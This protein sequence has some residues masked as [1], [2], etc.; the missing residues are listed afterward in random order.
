MHSRQTNRQGFSMQP[1]RQ[2]EHE[3]ARATSSKAKQ[4]RWAARLWGSGAGDA[5]TFKASDSSNKKRTEWEETDPN[6]AS[7]I[8]GVDMIGRQLFW[9]NAP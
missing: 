8:V 7:P 1:D 3:P 2:R 4:S 5:Y 9:A 6:Q